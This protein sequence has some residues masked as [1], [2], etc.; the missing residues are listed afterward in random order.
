M[1]ITLIAAMDRNRT[2]GAGNKLPW[3]LPAEMAYFTR[4]TLGKTVIMGRKTFESLPKPLKDR[5]NVVLTKRP[6]Y[7]PEGCEIVHSIEEALRL[8][9]DEELMVI[10]GAEIYAQF[11]PFADMIY[12]TAVDAEVKGGDAYFP[13]FSDTEWELAESE[14]R[15]ADEKNAYAFT[16]QTFKRRTIG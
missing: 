3:R 15:E 7:R 4:N 11:L 1:S 5:R 2:I 8:F 6:D 16:F 14:K 10:G 9:K 12:L 13:D